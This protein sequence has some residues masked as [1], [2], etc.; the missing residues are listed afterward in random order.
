MSEF[1]PDFLCIKV[2][3]SEG[4]LMASSEFW[5]GQ[6]SSGDMT[7]P[8]TLTRAQRANQALWLK[9]RVQA[10]KASEV[11]GLLHPWV[12]LTHERVHFVQMLIYPVGLTWLGY[13]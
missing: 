12:A 4:E 9:E 1:L 2:P 5:T 3:F 11:M 13:V 7:M 10:G 6:P 8:I